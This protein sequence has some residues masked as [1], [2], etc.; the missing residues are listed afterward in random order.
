MQQDLEHGRSSNTYLNPSARVFRIH[1]G[2]PIMSRDMMTELERQAFEAAFTR[3]M[4]QSTEERASNLWMLSRNN[5]VIWQIAIV[6]L[7]LCG[8]NYVNEDSLKK[9]APYNIR[10]C[11]L[12]LKYWCLSYILIAF[13]RYLTAI[14]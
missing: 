1:R 12:N 4:R 6:I 9:E 2:Q 5:L 3:Q 10:S 14:Y 7:I 11:T 8:S 13:A